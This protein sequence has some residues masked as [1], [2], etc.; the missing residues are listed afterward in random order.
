PHQQRSG[1][2]GIEVH[3]VGA[4]TIAVPAAPFL[5]HVVCTL[6]LDAQCL[7]RLVGAGS[8]T[9]G[10]RSCITHV[11]IQRNLVVLSHA[12]LP[13]QVRNCVICTRSP[14][15]VVNLTPSQCRCSTCGS[16]CL[17]RHS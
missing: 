8:A 11:R 6:A 14:C 2:I 5:H 17:K 16:V 3:M 13:R 10:T 7:S 1:R 4:D 9:I 15:M 12:N